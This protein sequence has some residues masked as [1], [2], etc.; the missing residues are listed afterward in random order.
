MTWLDT[1]NT[2]EDLP[3]SQLE[4][5]RFIWLHGV[6]QARTSGVFYAKESEFSTEPPAPWGLDNRFDNERGYSASELRI[7]IIGTRTQ[8]FVPGVDGKAPTYLGHYEAGAKKH[9]EV[10]CLVD[11]L[12]DPMVFSASGMN[13]AK[14]MQDIIKAY[15]DGLLKQASRIAK[16]GLPPWSFWLPIKN[17]VTAEG[18][19]A[20]IEAADS[21]GKTYGS[22]VTPP[23]LYLPGDAMETLF[24]GADALRRGADVRD[25]YASWFEARRLPP[26][27]LEGEVLPALPAPRNTPQEIGAD[28]LF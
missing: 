4:P 26:Q 16:R 6:K 27:V 28:E 13:K 19:T 25:T 10:L 24:V 7:A 22:V 5:G 8:W 3:T 12:D 18:K 21:A 17:K 23:A 1:V 9:L 14:P 2:I 20:Y 15:N 11:G